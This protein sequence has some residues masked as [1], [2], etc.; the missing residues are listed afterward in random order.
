MEL[1]LLSLL[2]LLITEYGFQS[3]KAAIGRLAAIWPWERPLHRSL[4][5]IAGWWALGLPFR[6]VQLAQLAGAILLG[7]GGALVL[8]SAIRKDAQ[9][10]KPYAR[11]RTHCLPLL[12]A[13]LIS[14][15]ASIPWLIDGHE[16][17]TNELTVWIQILVFLLA[18]CLLW[19]WGTMLTSSVVAIARHRQLEED[20][21]PDLG[22]GELIGILERLLIFVLGG[23]GLAAVG[24][25]VAAKSAARFPQFKDVEF[26]EYFLIGSLTSIGLATVV[27]LA[28][29]RLLVL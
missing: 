27:G 18:L 26:A 24:F 22:A 15:P 4:L 16:G 1:V 17:L 14:A 2:A 12:I 20:P 21:T 8:R 19:T 23:G 3:R 6:G 7:E 13:P 25:V 10:G 11:V 9:R 28:V 29:H 5:W